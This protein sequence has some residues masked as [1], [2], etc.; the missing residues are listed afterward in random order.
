MRYLSSSRVLVTVVLLAIAGLF[1]N[2]LGAADEKVASKD[3]GAHVKWEYT[4]ALEGQL[5]LGEL[6]EQGWEAY[7]VTH[8]P[9][10]TPVIYLKRVKK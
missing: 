10:R 9:N 2:G 1:A 4:S 6:G 8:E 7:A 3:A 5:K